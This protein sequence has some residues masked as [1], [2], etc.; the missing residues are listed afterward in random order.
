MQLEIISPK[1]MI[2]TGSVVSVTLPGALGS[3]QILEHHAPIISSLV[4]GKLS[5]VTDEDEQI[6]LLIEDGFVEMNNNKVT[7]C[8]ESIIKEL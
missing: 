2:F 8:L 3:F 7:V 6:E 1:K 5:F 4:K